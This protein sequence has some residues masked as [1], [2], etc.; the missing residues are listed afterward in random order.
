MS[1]IS[2][3]EFESRMRKIK[4]DNL[5]KERRRE[6]RKERNKNRKKTKFKLPS[7]SKLVLLGAIL[8]CLQIII[9]CEYTMLKLGDLSAMYVLIGIPAALAPVIL[10]YYHKSKCENTAGGIVYE[11]AMKEKENAAKEPEDNDEEV[12]G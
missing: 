12:K 11:T 4:R 2:E 7:T 1:Y 10:G 9:F 3:K 8:L 6:L 5:S